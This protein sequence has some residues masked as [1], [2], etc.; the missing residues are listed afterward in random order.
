MT[1]TENDPIDAA[2][3]AVDND[4][5]SPNAELDAARAELAQLREDSFA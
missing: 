2:E 5:L 1:T 3:Q 4:T